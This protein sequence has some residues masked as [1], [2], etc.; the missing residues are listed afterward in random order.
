MQIGEG[1]MQ[2]FFRLLS[3]AAA[4]LSAFSVIYFYMEMD[5]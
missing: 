2:I 5:G 3:F 1:D 4:L